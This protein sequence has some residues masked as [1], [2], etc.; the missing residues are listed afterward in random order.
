MKKKI[1]AMIILFS[2][3]LTA[4]PLQVFAA[5][6]DEDDL[7]LETSGNTLIVKLE[8]PN[9]KK[10]EL[11]SVQLSLNLDAGAFSD[12]IFDE[13]VTGKAKVYEIYYNQERKQVNLYI[14]GT[15]ALFNGR[16]LT[17]GSV[18]AEA[19]GSA[20]SSAQVEGKAVKV[21]RGAVTED[22]ELS[23]M[24]EI[25]LQNDGGSNPGTYNP[26]VYNPGQPVP[27]GQKPEEPKDPE[28]PD[29]DQQEPEAPEDHPE[30]ETAVI[31][32]R[33]L[34]IQNA[35]AGVTVKW[36]KSSNAAG[37]YVYRKTAGGRWKRIAAVS[38]KTKVSY[39]DQAVKSKNG[40][41]YLYTVKAYNGKKTSTYDKSGIKICRLTAPVLSKPASKSTAKMVVKWK[42]NKKATGYQIQY[43]RS[44]DFKKQK[45]AKTIKSAS[46]TSQTI[47]KL[48]QKKTYYVRIRCY[49]KAGAAKYYSAWSTAK[50]VKIK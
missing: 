30:G 36:S 8:L 23:N 11:S 42:Q 31:A 13:S 26:G 46:K 28:I 7:I 43:A 24:T 15:K 18:Q 39:T 50:K 12:F 32:P 38:G 4:I 6:N 2:L 40:K 16:S 14:A 21:V 9:A 34:K 25:S 33:L 37:Y 47:T 44:A 20:A 48:K 41:T 5:G 45:A 49:K 27:G 22:L 17:I 19:N 10:E 29:E 3:L 35:A 1:T